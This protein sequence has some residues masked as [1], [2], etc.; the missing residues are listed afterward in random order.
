M[1]PNLPLIFWVGFAVKGNNE[2]TESVVFAGEIKEE[3]ERIKTYRQ[4]I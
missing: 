4:I 3:I 2:L 1:I